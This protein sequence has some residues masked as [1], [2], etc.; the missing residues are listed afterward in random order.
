MT[1]RA[2]R[3]AGAVTVALGAAVLLA[4]CGSGG[5]GT[6][7]TAAPPAQVSVPMATSVGGS[8]GTAYAVVDM[9][10][11]A[12]D[13]ENFWQLFARAAGSAAWRLATPAGVASNGG[14]VAA[15]TG[16]SSVAAGFRPSQ[17]LTFS[18][19]ATSTDSGGSWSAGS[20]V[21]F[22][23]ASDP[24]ALAAGPAGRLI[25]LTSNGTV[26]VQSQ[27]Q[28][29][30]TTL[31]TER[32]IAASPAGR[33]CGLTR[34]TAVAFTA[35]GTPMV[36]GAC[37]RTSAPGIFAEAGGSWSLTGPALP[38]PARSAV[39]AMATAGSVTTAIIRTGTG[40]SARLVAAWRGAAGPWTSSAALPVS[41]GSVLSASIWPSGA[42]G[43]V[44]SGSRAAVLSGTGASWQE[45]TGLPAGT[46]TLAPE[47]HGQ[48]EALTA[49]GSSFRAWTLNSGS[50]QVV[51]TVSVQ[52][53]Y[54]SSG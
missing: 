48:A 50:W 22:G 17:D 4:A 18:P 54:G 35:Q 16:A 8:G 20:P 6:A 33:T 34:L 44:L 28:A 13:H 40:A 14:V 46:V 24:D 27:S 39:L 43:L 11:S 38:S 9:G 2:G 23:L 25:A 15:V 52:I 7:G 12:A 37:D 45:L 47:P 53:P 19:V 26:A 3:R 32:Q 5:Q 31:A 36:A 41:S 10:G 42:A 1:G 21:M 49:R 30:W 51:Q 29:A